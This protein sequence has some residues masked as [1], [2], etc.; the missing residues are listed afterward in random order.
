MKTENGKRKL[1][2]EFDLS[3]YLSCISR[4][5]SVLDIVCRRFPEKGAKGKIVL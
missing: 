5:K 2:K 4:A 1:E 3:S